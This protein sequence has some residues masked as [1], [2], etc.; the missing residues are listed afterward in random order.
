MKDKLIATTTT[1]LSVRHCSHHH[2][3]VDALVWVTVS[4]LQLV[5]GGFGVGWMDI[6]M[7]VED[8]SAMQAGSHVLSFCQVGA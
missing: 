3:L 1:S 4:T 6:H 7:D 8:S 2:H 5:A